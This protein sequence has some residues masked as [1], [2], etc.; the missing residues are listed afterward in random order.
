MR[1]LIIADDFT[2]SIDTGVQMAKSGIGT[3]VFF[4]RNG[5]LPDIS[6]CAD[7][8]VVIDIESRHLPHEE[9]Y[10]RVTQIARNGMQAGFDY[11]YKKTDS[12]LRGNIGA[13]LA[14]LLTVCGEVRMI[15]AP[16]FPRAGPDN[17][18]RHSARTRGAAGTDGVCLGLHQSGT[19][20]PCR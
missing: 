15:F 5:R 3:S 7:P 13:E 4:E 12:A 9:A 20:Q 11:F 2:G 10:Q 16:A 19:F 17:S 18:E 1:L 14:A 6:S 8:V